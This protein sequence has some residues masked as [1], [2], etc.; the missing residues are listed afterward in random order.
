MEVD[1]KE[2]A[3]VLTRPHIRRD[4]TQDI[5]LTST[6]VTTPRIRGQ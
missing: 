3:E 6:A 5:N 2:E 1:Q 4:K